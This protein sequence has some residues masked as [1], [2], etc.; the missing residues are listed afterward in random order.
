MSSGHF[1]ATGTRLTLT[2]VVVVLASALL[3]VRS[4][5]AIK[6]DRSLVLFGSSSIKGS[7]GRVIASD[8]TRMGFR[9]S[10]YGYPSAGLARPDFLDLR[11]TLEGLSFADGTT[12]VLMYFGANDGQ[13]IWSY[14]GETAGQSKWVSWRD[15]RWSSIYQARASA[16]I[17]GL[18]ARRVQH[19]IIMAP[20]DVMRP[21]LQERLARIRPVLR[22][23]AQAT[24]CGYFVSTAG[25][26][27]Q[28][29]V[30]G[31]KLRAPDGVHMTRA[32]ALRVWMRVRDDILRV[33]S[34]ARRSNHPVETTELADLQPVQMSLR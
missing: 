19:A 12:A 23:A 31:E 2:C 5:S 9:V 14:P 22:K 34:P 24:S 10:R 4:A 7:F 20:A 17:R 8:L 25:D 16:L 21:R 18:C 27:G 28:F 1:F 6:H 3:T 33:M 30:D 32:G 13:S 26:E 15:R 29:E 11:Q